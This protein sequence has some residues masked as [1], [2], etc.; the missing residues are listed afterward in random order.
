MQFRVIGVER[1][2]GLDVAKT[3]EAPTPSAAEGRANEIGILVERVEAIEGI[4]SLDF[5]LE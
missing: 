4:S 2:S 5:R 1:Q 3:I